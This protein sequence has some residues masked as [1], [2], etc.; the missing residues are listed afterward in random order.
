MLG[1]YTMQ[2]SMLPF[3]SWT[4]GLWTTQASYKSV[5]TAGMVLLFTYLI[6]EPLK[7]V[8]REMAAMSNQH[9]HT[10]F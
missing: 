6:R 2:P 1:T 10:D 8:G 4:C 5:K 3:G 7:G 9:I